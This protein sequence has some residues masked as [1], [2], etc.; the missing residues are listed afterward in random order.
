MRGSSRLLVKIYLYGVVT[1]VGATTPNP[2]F[3]VNSALVSRSQ[4]FEFQP[5]SDDEIAGLLQRA[6]ADAERGLGFLKIQAED[7]ALRHLARVADGD[8]RKA[9]N[10]LAPT[11]SEPPFLIAET[12]VM[13]L[14]IIFGI[15]A[16]RHFRPAPE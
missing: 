3:A 4:V 9:L 16:L 12:A 7:S 14:F 8:A 2:F 10:A 6:L 15:A 5:L 1:L 11:Q 13:L